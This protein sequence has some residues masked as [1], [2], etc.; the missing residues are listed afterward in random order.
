MKIRGSEG[1]KRR[2][3]KEFEEELYTNTVEE[4]R[5]CLTRLDNE[6]DAWPRH[7]SDA[8]TRRNKQ[9]T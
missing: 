6:I 7:M 3:K 5:P 8:Y 9:A 4:S 2:G 1:K